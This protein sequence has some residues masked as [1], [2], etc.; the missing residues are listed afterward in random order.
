MR[1][2]IAIEL[3]PAVVSLL[4][5]VQKKLKSS[6]LNIRWVRP[7]T[8]HLTLRFLG[9][10]PPEAVDPVRQALAESARGFSPISLWARGSG[11]FPGIKKPRVLWVGLSGQ[12]DQLKTLQR[13]LEENLATIGFEREKRAF[14]GHLT[15]GRFKES[16]DA[17]RL[18]DALSDIA[19][20]RTEPFTADR[21][22]LFQSVLKPS[23][24]VY[25]KIASAVLA[26]SL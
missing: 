10:V 14:S 13:T 1:T 11:V 8:I 3:P 7:E 6:G 18:N 4:E 16:V 17:A 24:P 12:V 23:G 20:F 21:I 25:S 19:E 9:E 2:F 26:P 15:L 5:Q 22:Y